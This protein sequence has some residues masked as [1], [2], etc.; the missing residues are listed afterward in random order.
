MGRQLLFYIL[1]ATIPVVGSFDFLIN[2]IRNIKKRNV[3]DTNT[4]G[5]DIHSMSIDSHITSRF[6]HN[7]ITS[8]AI[9][10]GNASKEA[11]FDVELPKTAFITNFTMTIDGVTY[12]G[13]I[14]EKEAAQK[15]YQQA[16]S[17]GQTAGLVKASGRKTEKFTVSVN[18]AASSEVVFE[19]VFEELLKRRFGYYEMFI[20]VNPKQ[21][22]KNF[23]IE[24]NIFEPQGISY[25][26]AEGSFITNDLLPVL[27]KSFSG[28]KGKVS[29]KPTLDQQRTCVDC[30]TTL[31]NGDFIVKYDVN[32]EATGNIQIV[33]GYFVHFFA[34]KNILRLPKNVVFIIDVS[35]SMRGR[36]LEQTREALLKILEDIKEDDYIN[37]VLFGSNVH[38]WKDTLIKA[39]PENLAEARRYVQQI[40]IAGWTNLNGG[41]MAGIELLN[42]AH[43]NG[44]L[45]ERSASLIIMLTDG[46]PTKGELNT[47]T[48]L[49][50]VRNAIQGKYPLYNLGFGYDLD[51]GS[52]E[53]MASENNGLA[54]R[55][56]EDSDS[57]LQLQGF[58]DEVANPLLTE[59]ELHYP[60]NAISDLTQNHFKHYYDGSEIVV[61]GRIIDDLLNSITADVK[62]HGA[63]D[64]LTFSEE[65]DISQTAKDFE[66][67]EY[68]FGDYIERLWSYLTIQQLLEKRNSAKGDEKTNLTAKVLEMS[69]KYK[70]VTPLTSM[71]VT[72]PEDNIDNAAIADKPLEA[73]ATRQSS[74]PS[75]SSSV[76]SHRY[77]SVDGDPHFIIDIPQSDDHLCFNIYE[78][79]GKILNL[80]RDPST[81]ITVNGQLIG[82]KQSRNDVQ[83]QNSY[84]GRLGIL[85]EELNIKLEVTPEKIILHN[86]T[87]Q[88][89]FTWLD[90]VTLLHPSLTLKIIRKKSLEVS[91]GEGATFV[92]ILH[93]VWRRNPT[94]GDFLGFYALDSHRFSERTHGLLGQFFHPINF[95]IL[96]V[97]SGST[98]EKPD[99]TMIVKNH[100][101][102]V[103]RG[104]QKDYTEDSKHGTNVTC[105]FIH[106]N[107]EGLIDGTYTDYI[108]SSLF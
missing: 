78:D 1:L 85:N 69:L 9:N 37:F 56:Y 87:K 10:L 64:D 52:L 54:R 2:N 12:P 101:L 68:I 63:E 66:D 75:Y 18:I 67:Q 25:L 94:H 14:K 31:L 40:D 44:S 100:Q 65:S 104:W 32:R 15:Q 77:T 11:F 38:K 41:L 58:Y 105:W 51:Y 88:M 29:F 93:Q 20:K 30:L 22:V 82:N 4:D 102:T 21:L 6:A 27:Q 61:A 97:H 42:E 84:I 70:F 96:E 71:V 28:K 33:N 49:E 83:P 74:Y 98:P 60:E 23:E 81:G 79:P 99:A 57:A 108:V 3:A 50:N 34:P 48:I 35:I 46:R 92:I 91:M 62:A 7:V 76:P 24:V 36:K 47:D 53:K 106:N 13:T 8:R 89:T 90:E 19:L 45:P 17:R 5:I 103:T 55:I 39:T 72:K 86:G 107:A 73:E 95:T 16:V 59:V 26:E 43:K 80:I